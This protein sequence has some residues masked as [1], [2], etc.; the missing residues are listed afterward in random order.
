M[1]IY[2]ELDSMLSTKSMM[3]SWRNYSVLKKKQDF[4]GGAVVKNPSANAGDT[5]LIPGPICRR[6]IPHAMEQQSWW[7]TTTEPVL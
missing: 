2:C 5:G 4:P 3:L 1:H 6:K 7:A